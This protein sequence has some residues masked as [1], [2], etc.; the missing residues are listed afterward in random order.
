[1]V[2]AAQRTRVKVEA[3][4]RP[5]VDTYPPG[6]QPSPG[7]GGTRHHNFM[8]CVVLAVPVFSLVLSGTALFTKQRRVSPDDGLIT[9]PILIAVATGALLCFVEK[10][11]DRAGSIC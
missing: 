2:N 5:S 9:R 7:T 1:M 8:L 6:V 11:T 4:N 10:L 3:D